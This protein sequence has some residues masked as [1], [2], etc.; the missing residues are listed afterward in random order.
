MKADKQ[1]G[2]RVI[3]PKELL[4]KLTRAAE[5]RRIS[6]LAVIR[7]ALS[8]WLSQQNLKDKLKRG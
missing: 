2:I 1:I 6:R 7:L 5:K 4:E 8:E 3:M